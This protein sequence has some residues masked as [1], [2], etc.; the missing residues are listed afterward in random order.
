MKSIVGSGKFRDG[1]TDFLRG[2]GRC[3]RRAE[4][5]FQAAKL[6]G[7]EP[8]RLAMFQYRIG[9]RMFHKNVVSNLLGHSGNKCSRRK[10]QMTATLKKG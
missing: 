4:V 9:Y 10:P 2:E 6:K 5:A 8:K 3:S 1:H 7:R